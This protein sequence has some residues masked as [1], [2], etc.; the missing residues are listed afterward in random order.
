MDGLRAAA[1][2]QA[3]VVKTLMA[4]AGAG[5]EAALAA[6]KAELTSRLR[7]LNEAKNKAEQAAG[8]KASGRVER[9]SA[10]AEAGLAIDANRFVSI[11]VL[12]K[13]DELG[14]ANFPN[15]LHNGMELFQRAGMLSQARACKA[16]VDDYAALLA[17]GPPTKPVSIGNTA[18]VCWECGHVG[19]PR[20]ADAVGRAM[21]AGASGAK[22]MRRAAAATGA[23]KA[24]CS[25]CGSNVQTNF[26][27]V[28]QSDGSNVPWIEHNREAAKAGSAAN[29]KAM[30]ALAAGKDVNVGSAS[31][32]RIGGKKTKPN[33][34]CPC[35]SGRKY[36]KCCSA[37]TGGG[38]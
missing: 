8:A 28:E 30:D 10:A 18:C 21:G 31:R 29:K 4:S 6:A 35:G 13:A 11:K 37:A 12:R 33:S 36:K 1:V 2:A 14:D 22:A 5:D 9:V 27:L 17:E 34:K 20:N 32:G 16:C 3:S 7:A 19:L 38:V 25:K 24:V 15:S 26:V 23:P